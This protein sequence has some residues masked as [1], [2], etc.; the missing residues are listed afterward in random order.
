LV[1]CVHDE[2]SAEKA[3]KTEMRETAATKSARQLLTV[4]MQ[5]LDESRTQA[6]SERVLMNF[7]KCIMPLSESLHKTAFWCWV[8]T[9]PIKAF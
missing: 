5:L 8:G 3:V 2:T 7:C 4:R 6:I 9:F 1:N